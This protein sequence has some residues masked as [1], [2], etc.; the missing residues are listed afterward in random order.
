M[1][2]NHILTR[3]Q[4]LGT[5][6]LL[7]TASVRFGQADS[8]NQTL[9]VGCQ[10]N[11]YP[12]TAG[13]F[14]SLLIALR[15]MKQ[16]RYAGFECNVRFVQGQ[17]DRSA[18]AGREIE[19]TGVQFI[20]AHLNMKLAAQG[21]FANV[22]EGVRSL[23]ARYIVMSGGGLSPDGRFE[24]DKLVAKAREITR[25]AKLCREQGITLAYHNHNP[26]F[27]NGNAEIEALARET[28]PA[29][30]H[31]LVDAG[32][33]YL[34]GGDPVAFLRRHAERIVGFHVKIFKGQTQVP[35]GH[36]DHEFNEMASAIRETQW[37]GWLITEEGGGSAKGNTAA[38]APDRQYIR[39]VFGV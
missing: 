20:G 11:G 17:F 3:R 21:D 8:R 25:I 22:A 2:K 28:D 15:N 6:P 19:R 24:Q 34:G 16:I 10:A 18:K 39:R 30:V 32:H 38:L 23:G 4:I 5:L 7:G 9:Q 37:K 35:L 13:D 14:A 27:A 26:E 31:F 36:G 1:N 29:T 12:L 33:A